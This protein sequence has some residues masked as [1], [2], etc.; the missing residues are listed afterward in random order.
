M[1]PLGAG[2][3]TA[4]R[5][6]AA[7]VPVLA[8]LAADPALAVMPLPPPP[9][10]LPPLLPRTEP[11]CCWGLEDMEP[12]RVLAMVTLY[13]MA[14]HVTLWGAY[15]IVRLLSVFAAEEIAWLMRRRR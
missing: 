1:R 9:E 12:L 3:L 14:C 4:V 2:R 13:V 7:A 11:S 8:V 5:A 15:R 6:V 10:G